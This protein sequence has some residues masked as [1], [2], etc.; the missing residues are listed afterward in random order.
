MCA[1]CQTTVSNHWCRIRGKDGKFLEGQLRCNACHNRA[2]TKK[3]NERYSWLRK[4]HKRAGADGS[5]DGDQTAFEPV[6]SGAAAEVGMDHEQQRAAAT[7]S[8][9]AARSTEEGPA[10]TSAAATPEEVSYEPGAEDGERNAEGEDRE[11]GTEVGTAPPGA[12]VQVKPE[13]E[14]PATHSNPHALL[15]AVL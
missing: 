4:G 10:S 8:A 2:R 12:E 6:S 9:L 1:D 11:T 7:M 13:E 15:A 14:P 3:K 5:E